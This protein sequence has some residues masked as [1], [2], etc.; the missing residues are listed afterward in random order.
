MKKIL[1]IF[2]SVAFVVLASSLVQARGGEEVHKEFKGVKEID[3]GTVSGNVIIKVHKSDV[4]LVDLVYEVDQ[5][6]FEYE[7]DENGDELEIREEWHGRTS[8]GHVVWTLTVP[9]GTDIEFSTASGDFEASGPFGSV[10]ASTASGDIYVEDTKGDVNVSTASGEVTL[11]KAYGGN[12]V[13]T[14]SGSITIE[15]S[16][17]KSKLSTAS[18]DINATDMEGTLR[19]STASGDIEVSRCRGAFKL[20]CASG[21]IM[22]ENVIFEGASSFSTASGEVEV[23]LA[24]SCAY[25]LELSTASGDVTLDYN[26]NEVKGYF[27]FEARKRRG[28]ISCPFDFDNEEEFERHGEDYVRKS[29]TRK[30]DEPQVFMS[31]ASGKVTLKK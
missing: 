3:I 14:A 2:I 30:G 22:V 27:E 11:K 10:K 31:T 23:I 7:F 5:G 12:K 6:D 9:N 21:T 13:S 26:G 25:D 19:L 29:F 15:K 20:S 17:E 8:S 28:R 1:A 16:N 18:G 24:E 4:V